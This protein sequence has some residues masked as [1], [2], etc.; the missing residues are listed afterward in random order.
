MKAKNLQEDIVFIT[1]TRGINMISNEQIASIID[2]CSSKGHVV[3]V[4]DIAFAL[5]CEC[6]D[7][8]AVAYKVL[9]GEGDL[10]EYTSRESTAIVSELVKKVNSQSNKG[11]TFDENK[12]EIIKLIQ[13]TKD[14]EANGELDAKQSLDLQTKLRVALNDKFGAK[15]EEVKEQLVIVNAKYNSV[16]QYCS[17]EI[18]VPTKEDLMK[19]YNLIENTNDR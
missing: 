16:C 15:E 3:R 5:L 18:Y 6:F 13:E 17:H 19:K 10:D 1:T 9:Y 2:K 7:D 14:K 12:A 4:R 11:I 8:N